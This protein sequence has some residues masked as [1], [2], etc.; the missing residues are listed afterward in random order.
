MSSP[1]RSDTNLGNYRIQ[2]S[3]G[4]G[5]MATVYH[6]HDLKHD[7]PVAVKILHASLAATF[8]TDRFQREIKVAARLNHPHIVPLLD[9]GIADGQMYY[10]MPYV[11]GESL[12]YDIGEPRDEGGAHGE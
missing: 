6:A 9:S 1:I 5:G 2:S 3:I 4:V 12:R 8:G 7:R 10:V 11:A